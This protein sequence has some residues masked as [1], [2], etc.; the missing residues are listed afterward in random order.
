MHVSVPIFVQLDTLLGKAIELAN[1]LPSTTDRLNFTSGFLPHGR[2]CDDAVS[3]EELSI[4]LTNIEM[5]RNS[6]SHARISLGMIKKLQDCRCK[7]FEDEADTLLRDLVEK[8][9]S[10]VATDAAAAVDAAAE[11]DAAAKK[12]TTDAGASTY[13][14]ATSDGAAATDQ[15]H[16][17]DLPP[18][19][20]VSSIFCFMFILHLLLTLD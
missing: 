1:Q 11:G 13:V 20:Q 4:E 2:V 7:P 3:K 5:L 15:F 10:V 6:I 8:E 16:G 18:T 19:H 12:E 14:P 17:D 9:A